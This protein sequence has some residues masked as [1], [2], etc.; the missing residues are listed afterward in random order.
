MKYYD[1]KPDE[2][3][4]FK[5]LSCITNLS[6]GEPAF[7]CSWKNQHRWEN[8]SLTAEKTFMAD[9]HVGM[10]RPKAPKRISNSAYWYSDV[11]TRQAY[12]LAMKPQA[13]WNNLSYYGIFGTYQIEEALNFSG[14]VCIGIGYKSH[15]LITLN[16]FYGKGFIGTQGVVF[17]KSLII[18]IV[19]PK[20]YWNDES[21]YLSKDYG[22]EPMEKALKAA[23][24][25]LDVPIVNYEECMI[26]ILSMMKKR[27]ISKSGVNRDSKRTLAILYGKKPHSSYFERN[28]E[29]LDL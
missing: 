17:E 4:G 6:D 11:A 22:K 20:Y 19:K 8:G 3:V 13:E 25:F 5:G 7:I 26:Y 1:I 12:D 2:I 18:G 10:V 29:E 15:P 21:A 24:K 27:K 14:R 16:K 9:A 28:M 23:Q